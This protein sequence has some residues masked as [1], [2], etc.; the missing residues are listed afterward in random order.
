[1]TG[2][3]IRKGLQYECISCAS[4]VDVCDE[5][6][7][8]MSYPK[9]LIRFATQN[10]LAQHLDHKQTLKRVARPRVLVYSGVLVLIAIAFVASLWLRK[11]FR[12][13]VVR[14]R[15]TLA[16]LVDDGRIENVYRLQVMNT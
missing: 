3:D 1:P 8:K 11:P 7:D 2:I 12:V 9:G 4:C 14:D 6:M 5:V 10:G 15:G 13:D 16:R